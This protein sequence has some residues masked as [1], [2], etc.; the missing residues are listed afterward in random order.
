MTRRDYIIIARAL[1]T[2][3]A[4][5]CETNQCPEALEAILRTAYSIASELA[6]D[7]PRFNGAHFMQVVRGVKDLHSRPSRNEVQS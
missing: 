1:R 5:A 7:N 6:N 2:T 4:S 3:Y